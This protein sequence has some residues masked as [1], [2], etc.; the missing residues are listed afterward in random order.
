MKNLL[1]ILFFIFI[2]PSLF[3]QQDSINS[4][5]L[6]DNT[7]FNSDFFQET[8]FQKLNER[9]AQKHLD[10]LIIDPI[11][12]RAAKEQADYMSVLGDDQLLQSGK[13]KTTESRIVQAGGSAFGKELVIEYKLKK[14]KDQQSYKKAI[15]E[16]IFKLLNRKKDADLIENSLFI[17]AGL[18]S[19]I[20]K[21][22]KQSIFISLVLGNYKSLLSGKDRIDELIVP[23]SE[24]NYGLKAY[25]SKICRKVDAYKRLSDLQNAL[26]IEDGIVYFETNDYKRFKSLMRKEK[27]GVTVDIVQKEQYKCGGLNIIDN[28]TAW[29]GIMTKPFWGDKLINSNMIEGKLSKNKVKVSIA[30]LPKGL[31]E[32]IELNLIIIQEK[33]ICADIIPNYVEAASIENTNKLDYLADTISTDSNFD[34]I[35]KPENTT[36]VFRIP[37]NRNKANIEKSDIN[38]IIKSLEEPEFIINSIKIEAFS[39]I[40]GGVTKNNKVQEKRGRAIE[41]ALKSVISTND[42]IDKAELITGPNWADFKKDIVNTE[43]NKLAQMSLIEAQ[44]YIENN[45]L[46]QILEPILEQH[47]YANVSLEIT[48]DIDGEKE[49]LYV[50]SRFNKALEQGDRI[51]ALSIQ[52]YIFKKVISGVYDKS[53][54]IKQEIIQ[55]SENAGLLM[56]KYWL[57]KYVNELYDGEDYCSIVNTLYNLDQ[58]NSYLQ[59]NDVYC[60][61]KNANFINETEIDELKNRIAHLYETNISESTIDALNLEYLF[62]IIE[63]ID[64][65]PDTPQLALESLTKIKELVDIEDMS[66]QNALKLSYL[67][68]DH[69]DYEYSATLLESFLTE[70]IVFEEILFT[71]ISLASHSEKR[72]ISSYFYLAIEKALNANPDRLKKLFTSGRISIQVFDNI[73]VKNLLC[74]KLSL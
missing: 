43:Y 22:K 65:V 39:S 26:F 68:I 30:K 73:K 62:N 40:E 59:F 63:A 54:V 57:L 7:K 37:F 8:F 18:S 29:K 48:Y 25:D 19:K 72:I 21:E 11:L 20:G 41:K 61:V 46:E 3:A 51:K 69:K 4:N 66:W 50:V 5:T 16:I 52:K 10:I 67:F 45:Q 71:Y 14:G 2:S 6:I 32:N 42:N 38:P 27:A 56:N 74:N 24:K 58:S 9:R 55:N 47:R 23:Y 49:Q 60:Q 34:Y 28:N 17:F 1:L 35:P 13:T 15:D 64:T 44:A 70:E 12:Q 36:L 31:D 53:A 33:H